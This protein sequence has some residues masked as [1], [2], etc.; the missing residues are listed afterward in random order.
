[1]YIFEIVFKNNQANTHTCF[2]TVGI[3]YWLII[4]NVILTPGSNNETQTLKRQKGV[5]RRN[6]LSV[7]EP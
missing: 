1:M 3:C 6:S 4:S 5:K 2:M 7:T